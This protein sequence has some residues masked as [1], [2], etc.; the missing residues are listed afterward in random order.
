MD[1]RLPTVNGELIY[2]K[3]KDK[4]EFWS[5]LL[6][7]AYAKYVYSVNKLIS[8][9]VNMMGLKVALLNFFF[10]K[11][12]LGHMKLLRQVTQQMLL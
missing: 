12:W 2:L 8:H 4:N 11:D 9:Y 6:E 1:D 10:V 7:K 3:S 5:A